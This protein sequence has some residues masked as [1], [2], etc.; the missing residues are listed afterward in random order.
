MAEYHMMVRVAFFLNGF[1]T[2]LFALTNSA[3]TGFTDIVSAAGT[4]L[5][6]YVTTRGLLQFQAKHLALLI[7]GNSG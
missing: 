5:F 2:L 6:C 4:A 1:V 7:K 3:I